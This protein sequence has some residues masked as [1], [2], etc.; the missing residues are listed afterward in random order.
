MNPAGGA[1]DNPNNLRYCDQTTPFRYIF[2]LS[3]GLPLPYKIT[4]SA[5]FQIYDAPG[6]GLFLTPPYFSARY[7]VGAAVAG[8][9]VTGGQTTPSSISVNL[10]QP[11]T[12]YQEYYKVA[13]MRFAKAMKI[14]KLNTTALAEFNNIF[15]IRSINSVTQNYGSN[16]LRPATVER[17]LNVR[18]GMQMRY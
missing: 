10:L 9:T 13:D 11:N 5:N 15:N 8:R 18:F 17:G 2:K 4:V 14:G 16:W 6:S 1:Q 12:I 7:D 3:G